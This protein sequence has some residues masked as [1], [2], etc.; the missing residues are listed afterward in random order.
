MAKK[1]R[2]KR[3]HTDKY[4]AREPKGRKGIPAHVVTSNKVDVAQ[5]LKF[6]RE[7]EPS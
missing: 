6:V 2:F 5:L 7:A 4:G 3:T 1:N